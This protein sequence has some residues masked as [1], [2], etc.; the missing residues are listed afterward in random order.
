MNSNLINL[1][2]DFN[3]ILRMIPHSETN[4]AT[5]YLHRYPAKFIPH[6]PRLFIRHLTNKNGSSMV[7]DPMCGSGTTLIESI[8]AGHKCVG[9]EIDPIAS[10]IA[11][12]STT[13]LPVKKIIKRYNKLINEIETS[14]KKKEQRKIPIP[15]EDEFPNILL[16][17]R[18]DVLQEIIFIRNKIF[19]IKENDYKNFLLLALSSIIRD[20]SNADP[21]D[22]FPERDKNLL[23]RDRKEILE[24]FR[25]SLDR[26]IKYVEDLSMRLNGNLYCKVIWGDARNLK[27]KDNSID[28]V[29][30]SPPYAYAMDYARINQLNTLLL[31][32]PNRQLREHRKVYV[33]TD[34]V[35]SSK[36]N[37][38]DGSF[39]SYEGFEF[40]RKEIEYLYKQNKRYGLC[41]YQYFVDMHQITKEIFRVLKPNSYF[42]YVVGNSTINRTIFYTDKVFQSICRSVGFSIEGILERPYYAYRM[43]RKRNTHSNTIKNDIFIIAKKTRR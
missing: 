28:L 29:F 33:G 9:V 10:L 12:V 14:F 41:L 38:I 4:Y 20:V 13:P 22:I 39:P 15:G 6:F 23:I 2:K 30:T 18:R 3:S 7:L 40:A 35:P 26:N 16:W 1:K 24:E 5:H 17:F 25:R 8:I 19:K 11:T 36:Y 37:I 27:I 43:T 32:M 42:V 31:I 21:R 34:R